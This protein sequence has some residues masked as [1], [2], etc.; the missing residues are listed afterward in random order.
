[1]AERPREDT[2]GSDEIQ[3]LHSHGHPVGN[4]HYRSGPRIFRCMFLEGEM[5]GAP[6]L[7]DNIHKMHPRGPADQVL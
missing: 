1:M 4:V 6:E 5:R 2:V 7:I 3:I